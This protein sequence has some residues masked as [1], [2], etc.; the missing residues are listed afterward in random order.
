MEPV[1]H[2]SSGRPGLRQ[3][4]AV[5]THPHGGCEARLYT[6]GIRISGA[7]TGVEQVG[8]GGLSTRLIPTWT[9]R[10][11]D[12]PLGDTQERDKIIRAAKAWPGPARTASMTAV[13]SG[14]PIYK[15]EWMP[16]PHSEGAPALQEANYKS[17]T[18]CPPTAAETA[19][20]GA[21]RPA[22][23]LLRR[24][25]YTAA[26]GQHHWQPPQRQKERGRHT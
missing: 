23:V 22:A 4:P 8:Q 3:S 24:D 15:T 25:A 18:P 11:E 7:S 12:D 1:D 16:Q 10:S 21:Q 19:G 2:L 14:G 13:A 9:G 26:E 5:P 20:A 17:Q 6:I